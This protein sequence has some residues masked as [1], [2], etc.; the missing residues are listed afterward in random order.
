MLIFCGFTAATTASFL[1]DEE[2]RVVMVKNQD[3]VY[4]RLAPIG[5]SYGA[6]QYAVPGVIGIYL[7]GL[8]SKNEWLHQTGLMM[9]ESLIVIGIIQIPARII[10]GRSRPLTGEKN[11]SFKLFEGSEQLKSSFISGH[12]AIAFSLSTILAEQIDNTWASIG[13]YAFAS[14]TPLSRLFEDKHWFSDTVIGSAMG[15]FI[16]NTIINYHKKIEKKEDKVL[17]IPSMNGVSFYYKF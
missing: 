6:P 16:A 14:L 1:L 13:L 3:K 10:A 17:L 9:T 15:F 2:A 11:S 8:I 4:D 12:S 7:T 5:F